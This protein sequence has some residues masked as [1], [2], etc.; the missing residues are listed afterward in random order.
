MPLVMMVMSSERVAPARKGRMVSGASVW[1]MKMEAA[2][3][4]LSAPEMRMVFCM[5]Q[6]KARMTICMTPRW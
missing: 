5:I 4:R 2:T 3:L 6:A 1:P